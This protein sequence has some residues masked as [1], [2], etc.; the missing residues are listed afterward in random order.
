MRETKR[1]TDAIIDRIH[2]LTVE[3]GLLPTGWRT[4]LEE[5]S[6]TYGR[7]WNIYASPPNSY[8]QYR[9]PATGSAGSYVGWSRR[10]ANEKLRLV[11]QIVG[12]MGRTKKE[13]RQRYGYPKKYKVR[14]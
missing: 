3:A 10:E 2:N 8:G 5:G 9:H 4:V 1:D 6:P 11:I 14:K 13:S 7:G 12:A